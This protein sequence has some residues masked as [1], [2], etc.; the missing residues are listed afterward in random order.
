M[1]S[2]CQSLNNPIKELQKAGSNILLAGVPHE[3]T[4]GPTTVIK[5]RLEATTDVSKSWAFNIVPLFTHMHA[6]AKRANSRNPGHVQPPAH[7]NRQ[8]MSTKPKTKQ[9]A[10]APATERQLK[11][12]LRHVINARKPTMIRAQIGPF[13]GCRPW[14]SMQ[15]LPGLMIFASSVTTKTGLVNENCAI[16]SKRRWQAQ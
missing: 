15:A 2:S 7:L 11:V 5:N 1:E 10:Q 13:G 3:K 12:R 8:N 16:M 6:R 9:A 4:H 14:G